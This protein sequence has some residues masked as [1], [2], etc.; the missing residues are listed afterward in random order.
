MALMVQSESRE[1][2]WGNDGLRSIWLHSFNGNVGSSSP[3][4]PRLIQANTEFSSDWPKWSK[5]TALTINPNNNIIKKKKQNKKKTLQRSTSCLLHL[6]VCDISLRRFNPF[7]LNKRLIFIFFLFFFFFFFLAS[8]CCCF[9]FGV[10]GSCHFPVFCI[11]TDGESSVL[12]IMIGSFK[13][14]RRSKVFS[15]HNSICLTDA[16]D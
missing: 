6:F 3:S 16:V 2:G 5:T 12:L 15:S 1:L 13:E 14:V 9:Y 4:P 11:S 8:L 10:S 7:K